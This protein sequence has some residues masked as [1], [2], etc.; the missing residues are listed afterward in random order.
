[1]IQVCSQCGAVNNQDLPVCPFCEASFSQP[2]SSRQ[3]NAP[4]EPEWRREVAR[5]LEVYRSR[6]HENISRAPEPVL[7]FASENIPAVITTAVA[8]RT[9][10][11]LRP[12]Q[13]VEIYSQPQLDFSVVE[14]HRAHPAATSCP[15]AEL[16]V[17][18]VAGLID[19]VVLAG[20]LGGFLLMFRSLGGQLEFLKI[21]FAIYGAIFFLIYFLYFGLFTLFSGATLGM[22]L[23]GLSVVAMDGGFPET[24]QL[25]WR[26]FGYLLSGA[27]L[28]LGFLWALWDEDH[29]TWQDRISHTYLTSAVPDDPD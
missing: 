29:L 19:A 9:I 7:P 10:A 17:R 8:P 5:R 15:L 4:E 18:R 25:A 26:S 21:N 6:R 28:F 22:Q 23:S 1:M 11:R 20:V 12:T 27:T 13:H 3:A 14:A 24:R 16:S 2:S